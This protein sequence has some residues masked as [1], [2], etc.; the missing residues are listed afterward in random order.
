[1]L[2]NAFDSRSSTAQRLGNLGVG[3][4]QPAITLI[5]Q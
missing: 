5:G 3:L 1:L 2:A 4:G